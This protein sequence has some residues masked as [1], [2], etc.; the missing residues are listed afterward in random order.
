[1]QTKYEYYTSY[2]TFLTFLY[3]KKYYIKNII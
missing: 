1:M 3:N 2:L